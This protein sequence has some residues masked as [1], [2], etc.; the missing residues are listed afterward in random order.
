MLEPAPTDAPKIKNLART[1]LTMLTSDDLIRESKCHD[2]E[3]S[4]AVI[5]MPPACAKVDD[6]GTDANVAPLARAPLP[7]GPLDIAIGDWD[8]LFAPSRQGSG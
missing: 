2:F 1:A 5:D 4:T 6:V 7:E 8:D 3:T